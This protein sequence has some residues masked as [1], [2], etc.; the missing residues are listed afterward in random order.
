[1][2]DNRA[3]LALLAMVQPDTDGPPPYWLTRAHET[4]AVQDEVDALC[5][6][7]EDVDGLALPERPPESAPLRTLLRYLVQLWWR[8]AG[9]P[10]RHGA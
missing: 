10:R 9:M 2:S 3:M 8:R 5:S 4:P 1:M 7:H 6:A